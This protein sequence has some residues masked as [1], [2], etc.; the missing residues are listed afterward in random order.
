M[1]KL[2]KQNKSQKVVIPKQKV[3]IPKEDNENKNLIDSW[4]EVE[5]PDW[6]NEEGLCT[7]DIEQDIEQS[8]LLNNSSIEP[9]IDKNEL[10]KAIFNYI[11][12]YNLKDYEDFK[13]IDENS[14]KKD[15]EK[16]VM[17]ACEKEEDSSNCPWLFYILDIEWS[18]N[19]SCKM[20]M[21]KVPCLDIEANESKY[22]KRTWSFWFVSEKN[23][24]VSIKLRN[25]DIAYLDGKI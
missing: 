23:G 14:S 12:G 25:G 22:A 1:G 4:L 11:N 8:D 5:E 24:V 21:Y 6:N 10:K 19:S 2:P 15:I 13:S 20:Y 3:V 16:A 17:L 7:A 18:Y 9:E